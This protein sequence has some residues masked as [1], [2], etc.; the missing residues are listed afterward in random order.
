MPLDTKFL[1]RHVTIY[2]AFNK[3]IGSWVKYKFTKKGF[4]VTDV[5]QRNPKKKFAGVPIRGKRK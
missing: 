2:Q 5:K 4:K 3:R 1:N